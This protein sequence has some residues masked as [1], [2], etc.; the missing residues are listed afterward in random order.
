MGRGPNV[1]YLDILLNACTYGPSDRPDAAILG[2]EEDEDNG[3]LTE[4]ELHESTILAIN[5]A[6]Q[7]ACTRTT[8]P[9]FLAI[10]FRYFA[11][12]Q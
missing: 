9:Y 5:A 12:V 4:L 1:N 8:L 6:L 3:N 10:S 7:I 2:H 11:Q